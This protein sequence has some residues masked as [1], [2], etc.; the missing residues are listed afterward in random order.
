VLLSRIRE[1]RLDRGLSLSQVAEQTGLSIAMLS[2]VERGLSDPSL[3][4][5]R[6]LAQAFEVP[7][8][9]LFRSNG[10]ESVAVIRHGDRRLVSSPHMRITYS[11]VSRSGGK[12]EVLEATLEP[13]AA[14]AESPRAHASEECVL[15]LEGALIVQVAGAEYALGTGDS[16]HFDSALPHRF[17]NP[18]QEK[19]RFIVS[20]TPPSW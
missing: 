4:S 16:C 13:G 18:H 5:L 2:Q 12:L 8:F 11:E 9:D 14:S 20:V 15:V 1:L 19:A 7:M 3:E 17:V 6:R 10:A